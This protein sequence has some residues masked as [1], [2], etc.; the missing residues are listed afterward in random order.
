MVRAWYRILTTLLGAACVLAHAGV[1]RGISPSEVLFVDLD[2]RAV[3]VLDV[4][5]GSVRTLIADSGSGIVRHLAV[6]PDGERLALLD[7]GFLAIHSLSEGSEGAL[8]GRVD[9]RDALG[10]GVAWAPDGRALVA[11]ATLG[12]RRWSRWF[13]DELTDLGNA[14]GFGNAIPVITRDGRFAVLG[15]FRRLGLEG[16]GRA[17]SAGAELVAATPSSAFVTNVDVVAA[18]RDAGFVIGVEGFD[19]PALASFSL[20]ELEPLGRLALPAIRPVDGVLNTDG[21][22]FYL[23]ESGDAVSGRLPRILSVQLADGRP[24]SYESF[25]LGSTQAA[26]RSITLAQLQDG[27]LVTVDPYGGTVVVLETEPDLRQQVVWPV[28][29]SPIV[30]AAAPAARRWEVWRGDTVDRL[31]T[32]RSPDAESPFDD[33]VAPDPATLGDGRFQAYRVVEPGGPPVSL[34]VDKASA[35]GTVRLSWRDFRPDS[36]PARPFAALSTLRSLSNCVA[37]D[38]S[39]VEW[40]LDARDALGDPVGVVEGLLIDPS[41]LDPVALGAHPTSG[42]AGT[43]FSLSSEVPAA[44][45]PALEVEDLRVPALEPV[46]FTA[47]APRAGIFGPAELLVGEAGLFFADVLGGEWPLE[48]S[49]DMNGDG[50]ADSA[51]EIVEWSWPTEGPRVLRLVVLD[52]QGCRSTATLELTVLAP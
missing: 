20:P 52:A 12:S 42:P 45:S 37:P 36:G 33:S 8:L 6:S 19:D 10:G 13:G 14:D 41:S 35:A 17:P 43:T 28:G 47:D 18:S 26:S 34:R 51:D 15:G 11:S 50:E 4:D 25:D 49:W 21:S 23:L 44:A 5:D 1:A 2:T 30:P 38:G 32:L 27:R 16:A 48:L 22:R 31:E 40:R 29:G 46:Q 3:R 7:D 24:E 9:G 39:E